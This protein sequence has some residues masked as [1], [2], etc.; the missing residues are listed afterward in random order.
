MRTVSILFALALLGGA[1]S[2]QSESPWYVQFG[3][4][5]LFSENAKDVPGGN[6]GF[7]P[8]YAVDLAIGHR[9]P[10][11]DRF[12]LNLEF[13]LYHQHFLVD[14]QDL[15]AIPSAVEEDNSAFAGLINGLLEW[16]FTPQYSVYG[17]F[18][19]GWAKNV[20]YDA[21]DSGSLNQVDTSALAYQAKLG[22]DYNLG[23]NY[24]VLLGYRY[25]RTTP[26]DIENLVSGQVDSI[27]IAQHVIEAT[28][29]WGL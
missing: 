13:E 2:A 19:L 10:Y 6:V 1:S 12:R 4:G 21:W 11:S 29:R 17:G 16:R 15:R 9:H 27:D 3:V 25:F 18:G 26:I 28:F 5:A 14:A 7:S 23:G 20:S 24:D 22:F 8:G